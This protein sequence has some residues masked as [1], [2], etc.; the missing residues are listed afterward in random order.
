MG[1]RRFN[2][3]PIQFFHST[4]WVYSS[5]SFLIQSKNIYFFKPLSYYFS[6]M[7][8]ETSWGKTP[9]GPPPPFASLW[10]WLFKFLFHY[11]SQS[12]V[13]NN[14]KHIN[15]HKFSDH[16]AQYV[17]KSSALGQKRAFSIYFSSWQTVRRTRIL[18]RA[19]ELTAP[20]HI[21]NNWKALEGYLKNLK[22]KR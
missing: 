6:G 12:N 3:P 10:L 8:I 22:N 14:N 11:I 21:K 13:Y 19:E 15:S 9:A 1:V 7:K 2:Q 16:F 5:L 20:L 4:W 18:K 17:W